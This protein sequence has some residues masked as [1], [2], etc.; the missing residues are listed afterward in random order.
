MNDDKKFEWYIHEYLVVEG[1]IRVF[2]VSK[3]LCLYFVDIE[4]TLESGI[5]VAPTFTNFG[6]FWSK[7]KNQKITEMP[8][9]M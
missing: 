6:K 8:R 1:A 9:L 3:K 5:D 2:G 7:Q 4:L